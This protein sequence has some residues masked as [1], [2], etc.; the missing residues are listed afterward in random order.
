M[1]PFPLWRPALAWLLVLG[2]LFIL[3]YSATNHRAATLPDVPSIVFDWER[4]IPLWPWT[5]VPYLS[6]DLLYGLS[7]LLC[8]AWQELHRHALRLLT[9]QLVCVACF[10]AFPLRFSTPRPDVQGWA[11]PL[12]DALTAVDLPYNQAPSLHI[13]LLVIL[14]DF[15]RRHTRGAL[16]AF[17]HVWSA[18]IGLSVLTTYQHHF[19]DVP[20]GLLVGVLCLGLWPLQGPL[21]AWRRRAAP[22]GRRRLVLPP[23]AGNARG[24]DAAGRHRPARVSGSAPAR[25]PSRYD[26]PP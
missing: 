2:P 22:A 10:F 21:P 12:F 20:T 8:R 11:G 18:L 3:S 19:I 5:I 16:R 9:A 25:A 23:Q 4:H 24:L 26:S 13:V 17:V 15:Y 14:W 6:L 7:L 1:R